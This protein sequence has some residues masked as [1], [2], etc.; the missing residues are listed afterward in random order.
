MPVLRLLLPSTL[1]I[2]L[3][4]AGGASAHPER[5]TFFPDHTKGSVPT[6]R[7]DGGN[8][9]TVCRPDSAERIARIYKGKGSAGT[10]DALLKQAA[11]CQI[12]EIQTAVDQ[13]ASGDRI[14]ILPGVYTEPT[15]RQVPFNDSKCPREDP[16]YWENTG[17]GH[18]EDGKV[19]TYQFHWDCKNSRN[20]I[21]ILGDSPSDEDLECD[22]HCNLQLEGMGKR[23]EDVVLVGDRKKRD[24]LRADRADGVVIKNLTAEQASFNGIDVVETNGFLLDH[25]V[26]RYNQNYGILTFTSDNGLYDFTEGHHNGDSGLYPGSGPEGHCLRYGIEIR[27]SSSHDNVLGQSGTAGN[28]TWVHDSKWFNNGVGIVND[29]FASGHPGMPQDCSKWERN[30]VYSNNTNY[31]ERENQEY[32]ANT[33]FEQRPR[34]HVCPQFQ[35]PVG[36]GFAFYGANENIIRDNRVWDNWRS[37]YRLFWVPGSVRGD[38]RPEAQR[39]TS[40]RNKITENV[41]GI[42]PDGKVMRNGVDV[43]WDEQGDGNCWENNQGAGAGGGIT[44]DPDPLPTCASGGSSGLVSNPAKI[45]PETTCATWDPETNQFPPGCSWFDTP[46]KPE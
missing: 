12:Q 45:G 35:S 22:Q 8:V 17:D 10:R 41:F 39:D 36:S 38:T 3:A 32:C 18:G 14:Q 37:G 11:T 33:P 44:S 2:F 25:A 24:V 26:G 9:I 21:Q 15:S 28:G 1:A 7:T 19:P 4:V 20:L 42:A 30:Q 34:E 43:Y 23:P 40:H 16:R 29:S 13:S 31:F 6:Y 46:P 27:N 5:T